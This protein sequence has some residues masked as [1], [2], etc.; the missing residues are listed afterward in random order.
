MSKTAI[1]KQAAIDYLNY[2]CQGKVQDLAKMIHDD[3]TFNGPFISFDSKDGYLSSLSD[4]APRNY[5]VEILSSFAEG[6]EVAL[7]YDFSKPGVSTPMAQ[8][9]KFRDGKIC[10]TLLIFDTRVF[11]G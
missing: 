5:A 2:F 9:F 4:D 7:F 1:Y 3:F 8:Y 10:A 11:Q 6:E